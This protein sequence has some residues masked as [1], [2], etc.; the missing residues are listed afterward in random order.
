MVRT[1]GP[2]RD[3]PLGGTL[4]EPLEAPDDPAL[5][6]DLV[7]QGDVSPEEAAIRVETDRVANA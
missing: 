5:D 7:P 2:D 3:A 1:G 6:A 4:V